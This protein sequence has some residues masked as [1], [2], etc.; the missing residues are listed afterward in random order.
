MKYLACGFFKWRPPFDS[1]G[2]PPIQAKGYNLPHPYKT[3]AWRDQVHVDP[4]EVFGLWI[5]RVATI[6]QDLL[7]KW[8]LDLAVWENGKDQEVNTPLN[9]QTD[10]IDKLTKGFGYKLNLD[11]VDRVAPYRLTEW[12]ISTRCPRSTSA[13]ANTS[14]LCPSLPKSITHQPTGTQGE[15]R[16]KCVSKVPLPLGRQSGT[17]SIVGTH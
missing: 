1:L 10:R 4:Q 16:Y 2:M 7:W 13:K 17:V 6:P 12:S 15:L 14:H 3:F 8:P 9:T 11:R 5:R